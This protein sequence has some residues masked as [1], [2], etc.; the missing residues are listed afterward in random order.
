MQIILRQLPNVLPTLLIN[1][2]IIFFAT[3][4]YEKYAR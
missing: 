3:I 2:Q 1:Q 4:P